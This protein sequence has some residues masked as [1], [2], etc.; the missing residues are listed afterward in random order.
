MADNYLERRME[1]LRNGSISRSL[2][3]QRPMAS[4]SALSG[5]RVLVCDATGN[6]GQELVRKFR[7]AGC[8]TAFLS[9]DRK[10]GNALAQ[11]CGARFYPCDSISEEAVEVA[12]ADLRRHWHGLDMTVRPEDSE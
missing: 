3:P 10:A 11:D 12:K 4:P 5:L 2:S 8:R 6:A 9:V 7:K 1:D